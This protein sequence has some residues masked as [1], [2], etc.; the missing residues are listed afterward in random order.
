MKDFIVLIV[1]DINV[2]H[3]FIKEVL[4]ISDFNFKTMH[5]YNGKEAIEIF[6]ENIDLIL[7]DINMPIMDG[8]ASTKEIRKMNTS[9]P[10]VALTAYSDSFDRQEAFE[11]GC[12]EF[13]SK[14]IGIK[15]LMSIIENF[16]NKK[17][18]RL[19]N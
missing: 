9:I 14:P 19:V 16:K 5:A 15:A 12:N 8:I 7:M 1:D 3:L 13:A 17:E 11:A 18:L 4:E 10:I 6:N 2:N